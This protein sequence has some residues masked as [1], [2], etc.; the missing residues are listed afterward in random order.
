MDTRSQVLLIKKIPGRVSSSATTDPCSQQCQNSSSFGNIHSDDKRTRTKGLLTL[1]VPVPDSVELLK[2]CRRESGLQILA[3][4]PNRGDA[5][6]LR[7]L[8]CEIIRFPSDFNFRISSGEAILYSPLV[9]DSAI[10]RPDSWTNSWT[11]MRDPFRTNANEQLIRE[12]KIGLS[13]VAVLLGLFLYVAFNKITRRGRHLPDRGI[14][15]TIAQPNWTES[16]PGLHVVASSKRSFDPRSEHLVGIRPIEKLTDGDLPE[17]DPRPN[18]ENQH[19]V[20]ENRFGSSQV[21]IP[22]SKIRFDPG[23]GTKINSN[24]SDKSGSSSPIGKLLKRSL[25]YFGSG[26]KPDNLAAKRNAERSDE[27]APIDLSKP[28]LSPAVQIAAAKTEKANALSRSAVEPGSDPP[29]SLEVNQLRASNAFAPP[30]NS[31]EVAQDEILPIVQLTSAE[32]PEIKKPSKNDFL[33]QTKFNATDN[34]IS[35]SPDPRQ[36]SLSGNELLTHQPSQD[37]ETDRPSIDDF[38]PVNKGRQPVRASLPSRPESATG[39]SAVDK[40][41]SQFTGLAEDPLPSG[42]RAGELNSDLSPKLRSPHP[43]PPVASGQTKR[44]PRRPQEASG[45]KS[46]LDAFDNSIETGSQQDSMPAK[47]ASRPATYTVSEGDSYWSIASR[48][49]GDGGFF[50]AL[51]E[52]NRSFIPE[53]ELRPGTKLATPDKSDLIKLWPDQCPREMTDLMVKTAEPGLPTEN[54]VYVTR[55]GDTLF[56]IAAQTLGQA[57]RYLEISRLNQSRLAPNANHLSPLPA[58]LRL[59]L[60]SQ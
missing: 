23:S 44:L 5:S 32:S 6:S 15:A 45:E 55:S 60:P 37:F 48:V 1:P 50:R 13:V 11:T 27:P 33:P 40:S 54:G 2:I 22:D 25:G 3:V 49:Y 7:Q 8:D 57:S 12:A 41:E 29:G 28:T 47:T 17:S 38:Q 19:S 52:H 24:S 30:I 16:S 35:N 14:E 26:K 42:E 43:L 58:G 36:D 59:V 18:A 10:C 20:S 31:L 53:F 51:Y 34:E 46:Q 39:K 21:E 9:V 4:V 56:E